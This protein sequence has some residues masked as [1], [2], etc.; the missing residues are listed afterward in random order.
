MFDVRT[1][2]MLPEAGPFLLRR[3]C[4]EQCL[5]IWRCS[6]CCGTHRQMYNGAA[7]LSAITS[8]LPFVEVNAPELC[9]YAGIGGGQTTPEEG[10][11][12]SRFTAMRRTGLPPIM[13]V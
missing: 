4:T 6:R 11:V 10:G 1:R 13:S 7:P 5:Q 8:V 3:K 9:Y 2:H 12:A